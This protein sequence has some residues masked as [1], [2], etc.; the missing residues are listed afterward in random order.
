MDNGANIFFFFFQKIVID[1]CVRK[2]DFDLLVDNNIVNH[3]VMKNLNF[4]L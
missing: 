4:N 3:L 1:Y 2:F